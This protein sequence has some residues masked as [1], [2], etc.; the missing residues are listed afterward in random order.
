MTTRKGIAVRFSIRAALALLLAAIVG[1]VPATGAEAPTKLWE[2]AGFE[3]AQPGATTSDI[4]RAM[5]AVL[6][7]DGARGNDVGRMG[8]GLGAQ[9]TEWPSLTASDETRL[10][11]GMVITLEPGMEFA[12]GKMMVHEENIVITESGADWLSRRAA[13]ELPVID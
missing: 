10:E 12:A 3:A 2:A 8:H 7:A 11:P 13:P 6:E 9:L 1:V 4:W 5:W